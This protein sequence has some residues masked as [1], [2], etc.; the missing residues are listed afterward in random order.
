MAEGGFITRAVFIT[1][2]ERL[3]GDAQAT[4]A[5]FITWYL[6]KGKTRS[7]AAVAECSTAKLD[8]IAMGKE[9]TEL[10]D[11]HQARILAADTRS[12]SQGDGS[13]K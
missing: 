3:A 4:I 12:V 1:T 11:R 9:V 8:D 7:V 10:S 13:D 6:A 5:E 2:D